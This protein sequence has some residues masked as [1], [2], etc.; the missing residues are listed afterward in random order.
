MR[1]FEL[2][3]VFI[4]PLFFILLF[5]GCVKEGDVGPRG[6][7]GINGTNGANGNT[8]WNGTT[9]PTSNVGNVGDFYFQSST[10]DFYGPKSD[11]GW[12]TP[13][14][15][16]GQ[17]GV[18]GPA[19]PAG[20]TG[21]TGATGAAGSKILNGTNVP[22]TSIGVVGDYYLNVST[23]ELYG[24]KTANSWGSPINL[25]GSSG[26]KILSGT[27]VPS[28]TLG[29][30]GDYY[31]RTSTAEFY[32]P[33]VG[34]S[35]GVPIGLKG[36]NGT[37][38]N[39]GTNGSNGA[40]ILSGT[41]IPTTQGNIGDYYF[42]STTGDFY[43]P[44]TATGWGVGTSLKGANGIDGKAGSQILSGTSVPSTSLG[45]IGDFYFRTSTSD[46]YGPK[47]AAGW[48]TPANLKGATGAAGSNGNN[49]TN[50]AAGS[51]IYSGKG[52]PSS[53]LGVAGDYYIN[54]TTGDLYGPKSSS[55]WGSLIFNMRGPSTDVIYSDW[56][57]LSSYDA[58]NNEGKLPI[59]VLSKY[60][61]YLN[62]AAIVIYVKE[63]KGPGFTTPLNVY[64]LNYY[65]KDH[66]IEVNYRIEGIDA[67]I[68]TKGNNS[69]FLTNFQYRYVII[70]GNVQSSKLAKALPR[71]YEEFKASY[72]IR[73]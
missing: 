29:V 27:T 23:S 8:I 72:K 21:Q 71:N 59:M 35:W 51:Q 26:S 18:A 3:R 31:F 53:S 33:K 6:D 39:N 44:K 67:I 24:P 37:N 41:A 32:G 22:S 43:G 25:K 42:R 9:V 28:T 66:D 45:N 54:L 46:F 69:T 7:N 62:N 16:K 36:A 61:D 40:T 10:S 48:G 73:D 12:G 60:P 70:P 13:V 30:D 52:N 17:N 65:S 1:S 47:T 57:V 55:G 38:G 2:K 50:G 34:N 20:S 68:Y 49:G 5:C 11:L 58:R 64:Q 63:F 4:V 14:N 19:G 15:L 56:M